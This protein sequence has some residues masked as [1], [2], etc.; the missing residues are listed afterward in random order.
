MEHDA[1][2]EA[3]LRLIAAAQQRLV[4]DPSA[5]AVRE[6]LDDARTGLPLLEGERGIL[7]DVGSGAGFP[8]LPL[9]I[10][11]PDLAGVLLE[12]RARRCDHLREAVGACDL[13]ERVHVVRDRAEV[14]AAGAGRE[15][16]DIAVARALAPPPVALELCVPLVRPGGVVLLYTGVCDRNALAATAAALGAAVERFERTRPDGSRML[17]LARRTGPLPE[18]IPRSAA[19]A[20][21]RPLVR[22]AG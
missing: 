8:G 13:A 5:G 10:S 9:L 18:G 14:Y 15:A 3:I 2:D 11:R 19:Q 1:A 22:S 12:S 17:V 20:R 7:V 6:H 21:K 16:A 4:A